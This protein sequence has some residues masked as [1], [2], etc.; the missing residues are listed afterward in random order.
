MCTKVNR[1]ESDKNITKAF[2]VTW[3]S[4]PDFLRAYRRLISL[5]VTLAAPPWCWIAM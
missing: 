1:R 4:P 5:N 3:P 2:A